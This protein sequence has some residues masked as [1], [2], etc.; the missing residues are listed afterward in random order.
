MLESL[1]PVSE[2]HSISRTVASIFIPQNFL[3]P[4]DLFNRL[5]GNIDYKDYPKKSLTKST[6]INFNQGLVDISREQINGFL[7]ESYDEL[8][9]INNLLKLENN[10]ENQGIISLENRKYKNWNAFKK[11]LDKDFNSLGKELDFYVEAISLK[12]RD[13]FDWLDKEK[14]IPVGEIFNIDSELLNKKFLSS[15]NGTLVLVSQS[16]NEDGIMTE[17]RT[18]ISFNK[19]LRKIIVEHTYATRFLE[20]VSYQNITKKQVFSEKY[21]LAHDENKRMLKDILTIETQTKINLK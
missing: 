19:N 10:K 12:Y 14:K 1:R 20:L 16:T 21:N 9:A 11:K 18:E 17:E 15:D 13:E 8:G 6:T 2:N 7:F 5:K 4:Q 3:K